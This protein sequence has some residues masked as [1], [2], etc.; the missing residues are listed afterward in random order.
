VKR[1]QGPPIKKKQQKRSSTG[2]KAPLIKKR[3]A[4]SEINNTIPGSYNLKY[5]YLLF[6]YQKIS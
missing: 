5:K 6:Y 2:F 1:N 4:I 3:L